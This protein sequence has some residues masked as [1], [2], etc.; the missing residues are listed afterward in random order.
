MAEIQIRI[1][2]LPKTKCAEVLNFITMMFNSYRSQINIYGMNHAVLECKLQAAELQHHRP[3][4]H[5]D[6][7]PEKA[8]TPPLYRRISEKHRNRSYKLSIRFNIIRQMLQFAQRAGFDLSFFIST[9][10]FQDGFSPFKNDTINS[11]P[12]SKRIKSVPTLQPTG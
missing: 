5:R 7:A 8:G 4:I 3:W 9:W 10:T 2:I 11:L 1:W 12:T 6:G